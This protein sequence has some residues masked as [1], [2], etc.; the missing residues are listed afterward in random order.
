LVVL[1]NSYL[2]FKTTILKTLSVVDVNTVLAFPLLLTLWSQFRQ[3]QVW[4]GV[5]SCRRPTLVV[6]E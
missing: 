4:V 1:S 6:T 3:R 2:D 5:P